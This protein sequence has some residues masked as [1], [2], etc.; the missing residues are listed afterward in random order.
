MQICLAI[1]LRID[2]ERSTESDSE[3]VFTEKQ[4]KNTTTKKRLKLQIEN[5]ISTFHPISKVVQCSNVQCV[6]NY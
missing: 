4:P 6:V 3:M 1:L 2:R 5:E